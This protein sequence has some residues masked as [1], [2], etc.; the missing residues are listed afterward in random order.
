[1]QLEAAAPKYDRLPN[2]I[3]YRLYLDDEAQMIP[4]DIMEY[5][6]EGNMK[7]VGTE[8][9]EI[10]FCHYIDVPKLD[11]KDII[12]R[13]IR[14]EYSVCD[15]LGILRQRD[16]KK[17]EFENYYNFAENAKKVAKRAIS[18]DEE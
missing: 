4:F 8:E 13:I 3:G 12:E 15:E 7:V 18:V 14:H 17:E 1:M 16:E 5:D 2:G 11:Y 10:H 9:K 6:E